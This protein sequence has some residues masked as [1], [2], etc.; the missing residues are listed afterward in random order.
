MNMDNETITVVTEA[1]RVAVEDALLTKVG[2]SGPLAC[3]R[4]GNSPYS[5][6]YV[7][8]GP[9]KPVNEDSGWR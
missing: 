6:E 7:I 5:P 9:K 1:E 8:Y 4:E 2:G 3:G